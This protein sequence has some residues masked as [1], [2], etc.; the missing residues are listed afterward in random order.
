MANKIFVILLLT[1][2]SYVTAQQ[3]KNPYVNEAVKTSLSKYLIECYNDTEIV[4]K[5]NKLPMTLETFLDIIRKVEDSSYYESFSQLSTS[6]LQRF[7]QDGVIRA[8][9]VKPGQN[10][11]GVLIYSPRSWTNDKFKI[12]MRDTLNGDPAKFHNETLTRLERVSVEIIH[13]FIVG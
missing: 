4:V 8:A 1:L 11:D 6:I 9:D 12:I 2:F 13:D 3:T 5:D 7:R 10:M